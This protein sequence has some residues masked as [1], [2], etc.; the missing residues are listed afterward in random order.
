[1]DTVYSEIRKVLDN[2]LGGA[3]AS[4]AMLR[5]CMYAKTADGKR[6]L[7]IT[8]TPAH[9]QDQPDID[10]FKIT[11]LLRAGGGWDWVSGPNF[12]RGGAW[13]VDVSRARDPAESGEGVGV[14]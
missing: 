2:L 9:P 4:R 10:V 11:E 13:H 8:F 1:M 14:P 12:R 7:V 6:R 5:E 3:I